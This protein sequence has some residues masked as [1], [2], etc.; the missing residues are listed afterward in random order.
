MKAIG[1]FKGEPI[2]DSDSLVDVEVPTP[3]LAEHDVLVEVKAVS[4][5]PVDTKL[6]AGAPSQKEP[7]ILGF[8]AV[9]I[10]VK[11][12]SNTTKFSKGD[13]VWYSGTTKRPGSNEAYQAVDERLVAKA[14]RSLTDEAAAAMP[15]TSITAYELLFEKMG[16]NFGQLANPGKT[17]LIVNGAGGVGSVLS[18]LAKWAGFTVIAT[19]SPANFDW[20]RANGVDQPIDYHDDLETQV[21][22]LGHHFVDAAVILYDVPSYYDAVTKLVAPG[23]HIGAIVGTQAKLNMEQL[24]SKS[25]SLDWEY[26]FAKGDFDFRMETQGEALR[27]IAQ[28]VDNNFVHTTLSRTIDSG[29]NAKNLREAHQVVEEGHVVGKVVVSGP[30]NGQVNE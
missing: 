20:L 28:L 2:T 6:R 9:G 27:Q 19:A 22:G 13:R 8:D 5:N 15:L 18:Q 3:D 30:F 10:V 14:P 4:V 21:Q 23:G 29:L 16:A 25:L 26:M 12:G 1:S 17:L 11:T 7:L 24:K